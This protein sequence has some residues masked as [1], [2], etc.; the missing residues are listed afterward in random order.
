[1]LRGLGLG[2]GQLLDVRVEK[3]TLTI[4]IEL[5]LAWIVCE[6]V[7]IT[8]ERLGFTKRTT[9][10][11]QVTTP[12]FDA[13]GLHRKLFNG[14]QV[15]LERRCALVDMAAALTLRTMIKQRHGCLYGFRTCL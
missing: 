11:S 7:K 3:R 9:S 14:S 8:A 10:V 12:A 2:V 15:D 1:M 4:E 6:R 13:N 5:M